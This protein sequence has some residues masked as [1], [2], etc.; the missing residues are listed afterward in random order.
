MSVRNRNYVELSAKILLPFLLFGLFIFSH[1]NVQSASSKA[2]AVAVP[3]G[4]LIECPGESIDRSESSVDVVVT[5]TRLRTP[6]DPPSEVPCIFD[7]GFLSGLIE[8]LGGG[9]NPLKIDVET[10]WVR[11]HDNEPGCNED[12]LRP[13]KIGGC[14]PI[15][16]CPVLWGGPPV[17]S[18]AGRC[19]EDDPKK[20]CGWVNYIK[21][22]ASQDGWDLGWP[23]P[24]SSSKV[25]P[26]S[27][28]TYDLD[29]RQWTCEGQCLIQS[30]SLH[31][32]V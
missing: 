4:G 3:I 29:T 27:A 31:E 30:V 1:G 13:F 24:G 26:A 18:L 8:I 14:I 32:K 2:E 15:V 9:T 19:S 21:D 6:S 11:C 17:V 28:V 10:I 7:T 5:Y 25:P 22:P 23:A 16:N 20:K 12:N